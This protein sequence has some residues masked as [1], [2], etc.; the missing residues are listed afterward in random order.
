MLWLPLPCAG[1]VNG[2][3]LWPEGSVR[4]VM[5]T[6]GIVENKPQICPT[7]HILVLNELSQFCPKEQ[8]FLAPQ[9]SQTRSSLLADY[10]VQ[11]HL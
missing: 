8:F 10:Q 5:L 1:E 2:K 7:V 11:C 9:R 6:L 4:R 3:G